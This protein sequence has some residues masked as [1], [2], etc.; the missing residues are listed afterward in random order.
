ML[1][2]PVAVVSAIIT[3]T[4]KGV[5]EIYVQTRWKPKVSPAYS[6]LLEIPVGGI[7]PYENVY[8]T[9]RREVKEETNLDIKAIKGEHDRTLVTE[10]TDVNICFQ[11]FICHQTINSKNGRPWI[12]FVFLCE[13]TGVVTIN[14]K[15]AKNPRWI[16]ITQL[17]QLLT[18]TPELIFPLQLPILRKYLDCK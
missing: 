16:S 17:E 1:D 4:N 2:Q 12:G 8:E 11:P 10:G 13:V 9:I 18:E 15:E 3:R 14:T 7:N 5:L 6:G